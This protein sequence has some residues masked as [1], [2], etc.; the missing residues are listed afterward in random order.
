MDI[1]KVVTVAWFSRHKL[2][3]RQIK[4]LKELHGPNTEVVNFNRAF[5]SVGDCLDQLRK[6]SGEPGQVVYTSPLP[7]D[8]QEGLR[9]SDIPYYYFDGDHRSNPF[10][11]YSVYHVPADSDEATRIWCY[12]WQPNNLPV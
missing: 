12:F 9:E 1:N 10:I 5:T 7:Y 11:P 3:E 6:A 8:M 4:V 2:T